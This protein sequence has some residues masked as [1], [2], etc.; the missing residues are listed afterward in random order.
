MNNKKCPYCGFINFVDAAE[1]RK[2]QTVLTELPEAPAF[3]DRPTYRGGV[4]FNNQPYRTSGGSKLK[5][6]LIGIAGFAFGASIYVLAIRPHVLALFTAKCE[7]TEYRLPGSDFTVTMP[8]KP[9]QI[10]PAAVPPEAKSLLEHSVVTQ[11]SGQG[12]ATFAFVD[13]SATQVDMSKAEELLNRAVD[14]ALERSK[15]RLISKTSVKFYG[16]PAVEFEC[17]PPPNTFRKPGHAYGK[18]FINSSRLYMLLIAGVE[19]SELLA[20]RDKFLSPR[21]GSVASKE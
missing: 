3:N 16:M 10:D 19:D 5:R 11:V 15:S 7:W 12:E 8:G 1:C 18:F 6:I 14:G 4:T 13:Y 20:G 2:C 9:S 21:L 17:E